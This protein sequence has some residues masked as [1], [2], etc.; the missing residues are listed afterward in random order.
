MI[1]GKRPLA[2]IR[3]QAVRLR[4]AVDIRHQVKQVRSRHDLDPLEWVLEQAAGALVGLIHRLAVGVEQI[5]E[6]LAWTHFFVLMRPLRIRLEP[7]QHMKVVFQ[8]AIGI[9]IGHVW[10]VARI[11]IEEMVIVALFFKKIFAI[12]ATIVDVVET[13]KLK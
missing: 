3:D 2:K 12:V 9:R 8:E 6:L 11:Q 4:V 10:D 7:H 5:A 1:G 13:T